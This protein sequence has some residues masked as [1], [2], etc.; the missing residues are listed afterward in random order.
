[1]FSDLKIYNFE[2]GSQ[3]WLNIRLGL[4]TAS[5]ASEL[6][7]SDRVYEKYCIKKQAEKYMLSADNKPDSFSTRRGKELEPIA[8]DLASEYLLEDIHKIGF[9][10]NEKY[11]SGCSPDGY[12][13]RLD[14][15]VEIKC[16][17]ELEHW[18]SLTT[19]IDDK[20]KLQILHSMATTNAKGWYVVNYNPNFDKKYQF[21]IRLYTFNS[22]ENIIKG[23]R[24]MMLDLKNKI[25]ENFKIEGC[26]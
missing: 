5:E 3:E 22:N 15:G 14:Y 20:T 17:E 19:G 25:N 12:I 13:S 16:F 18:K 6:M 7:G 8:R 4:T 23:V 1:M 26:I 11:N 2:Q 9:I 10:K 21:A 24:L